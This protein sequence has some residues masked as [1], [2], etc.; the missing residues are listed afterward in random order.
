[1]LTGYTEETIDGSWALTRDLIAHNAEPTVAELLAATGRLAAQA[2]F[3]AT[4]FR[5]ALDMA[6]RHPLLVGESERRLP[7]LAIVN[8]S[9]EPEIAA[10]IEARAAEGYTTLKVK[11]GFDREADLARLRFIQRRVAGTGSC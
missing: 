5:T 2:P 6:A 3:T 7:M 8:A 4:A 1:M 9:T 10:E 11:V